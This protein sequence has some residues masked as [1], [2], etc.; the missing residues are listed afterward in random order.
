[1]RIYKKMVKY[2]KLNVSNLLIITV[3]I[4]CTM[5]PSWNNTLNKYN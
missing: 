4:K 1:M 3:I 2:Y 5:L